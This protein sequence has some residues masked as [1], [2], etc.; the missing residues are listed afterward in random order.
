[1]S[2]GLQT[3]RAA[4]RIKSVV[5]RMQRTGYEGFPVVE[6]EHVV[7]LLTRR[8]VDR[9]M[10]HG[11]GQRRVAEIME[12]G[13]IT[14]QPSD[15]IDV[16]H[17]RMMRSGWGQIPVVDAT[18]HLI[19]I[20]TRTDLIKH[21]G[22]RPD[23]G[24]RG[25]TIQNM[26]TALAPGLWRLLEAIAL[27][28]QNERTGLYLVG[29]VVRDLLLGQPN[30][31]IDLVV[32][33]DAIELVRTIC[34]TYGGDMRSHAQFG[35]AKWLPDETVAAALGLEVTQPGWPAF[36]DFAAARI[37]FYEQPTALPT[38]QR[39]S[40]KPDLYR[41]DFTINTLAIR[42]APEPL[43]DLLDFYGGEQDLKDGVI[44]VLHSLSFVDDP[45]RILRAVRLEQRLG[46][47]IEPRSE[48]LIGHAV[49]LLDR[50]SGDRIRHELALILNEIE[51]LRALVRLE[52]LG[53]LR[54]LHP[55]LRVDEWLRAAFYAVRYA[56]QQHPW[57][58][59]AE[60][61]NW[62][63]T[64]FALLT[65]R[66]PESDLE[67]LGRRL[68]FSRVYLNHL[69]DARTAITTLDD[70]SVPQ[71]P[72]A[73][74]HWLEPLSEVGWLAAWAAAPNAVAREH[75]ARFAQEW[76]FVRPVIGGHALEALTGLKPGPVYGTLLGSLRDA[77]LDGTITTPEEEQQMLLRLVADVQA[78]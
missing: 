5:E 22:Q 59:L 28:A 6:G 67:E 3:V 42:L 65:S 49:A 9:A 26:R 39:G 63:L 70:L 23:T 29:G 44:R 7:G 56:R 30:H 40:I 57:P 74:V 46:F 68:Q 69:H 52:Q 12:A 66:L 14:V 47:R 48:E 35:T 58:S 37:E 20:V 11:M 43:G 36:I 4:E 72:S 32:E 62:M 15:S 1:M 77:W 24:R 60:F 73:I 78:E 16:L 2:R 51:P 10:S 76:R 50:V 13:S 45:T 19:G 75:I 71:P 21:W 33:G 17:Q 25:D 31:D 27:L 53:V 64:T 38:V 54:A 8:D 41:R 55:A 61:D 18:G 34:A